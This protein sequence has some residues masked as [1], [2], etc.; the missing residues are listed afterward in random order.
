MGIDAIQAGGEFESLAL[1]R[2]ANFEQAGRHVYSDCAEVEALRKAALA[3]GL[4]FPQAVA[5]SIRLQSVGLNAETARTTIQ[6]LANAIASTGGT[7]QNLESVTV[8]MAQMISKGKVLSQDLRIIQENLPIISD[9]MLKAFGTA[10]AEKIQELGITGKDFVKGITE[11]MT[12]LTGG[13]GGKSEGWGNAGGARKKGGRKALGHR[14][15]EV[16]VWRRKGGDRRNY[17]PCGRPVGGPG[18]RRER[19]DNRSAV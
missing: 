3:P 1:A 15:N 7:A 10:N 6:E 11:E 17:A 9:L 4:D 19:R 2:E 12:K 16:K 5:A 8:Q 18:R 14:G 13:Q